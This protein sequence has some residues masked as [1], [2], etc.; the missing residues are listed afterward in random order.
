[1]AD[2]VEPIVELVKV[3]GIEN[4]LPSDKKWTDIDSQLL[5]NYFDKCLEQLPESAK[6]DPLFMA[7][8]YKM[9]GFDAEAALEVSKI[10][11]EQ[12]RMLEEYER[13]ITIKSDGE[14]DIQ[15]HHSEV[16]ELKEGIV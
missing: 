10:E 9:Y 5:K 8:L 13:K 16:T 4:Y 11:L 7:G 2:K 14:P 6:M 12:K 15:V 1:M 3:I